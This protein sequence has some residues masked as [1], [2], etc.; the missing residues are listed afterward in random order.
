[1][2]TCEQPAREKEKK[3]MT[4]LC[5]GLIGAILA[6]I[7]MMLWYFW[8][9]RKEFEAL[10]M[11]ILAECDYV[12]LILDEVKNGSIK[13]NMSFKRLPVDYFRVIHKE[14]IKYT[15][16]HELFTSVSRLFV[17]MDLFNREVE[18]VYKLQQSGVDMVGT[19]GKEDVLIKCKPKDID[20]SDTIC[21]ARKGVW[22]SLMHMKN[23]LEE[24]YG[25][26]KP[27]EL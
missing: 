11:S 9:Q 25:T 12:L 7:C 2:S 3:I 19:L 6:Q 24:N 8:K 17:D 10:R 14:L 26:E 18:F 5:S 13:G 1:M 16:D 22:D 15:K 23:Y 4:E 20:I 21:G 27:N